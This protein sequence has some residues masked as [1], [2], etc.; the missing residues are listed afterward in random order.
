MRRQSP[1][2]QGR[3]AAVT[4]YPLYWRLA[5]SDINI[6]T[7]V[8]KAFGIPVGEPPML[9]FLG[10]KFPARHPVA[11][12]GGGK[13]NTSTA[14]GARGINS[15]CQGRGTDQWEKRCCQELGE[16][17]DLLALRRREC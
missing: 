6:T 16:R 17:R 7:K 14:S 3:P 13:K 12:V 5:N 11:S 1:T 15:V 2:S 4:Y 8:A 10:Q 9:R